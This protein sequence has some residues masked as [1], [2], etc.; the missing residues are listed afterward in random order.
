MKKNKT[1][2]NDDYYFKSIYKPNLE[3]YITLEESKDLYNKWI[4]FEP[5]AYYVP[6]PYFYRFW[7]RS[8]ELVDYYKNWLPDC[9][10]YKETIVYPACK[11]NKYKS[12]L[13]SY[14]KTFNFK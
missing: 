6:S 10:F 3:L 1:R 13:N 8:Y 11:K 14:E 12:L 4:L 9:E 7:V 5:D 2:N